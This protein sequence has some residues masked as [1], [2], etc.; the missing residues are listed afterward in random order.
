[1][2]TLENLP[3][4]DVDMDTVFFRV[5]YNMLESMKI[6]KGECEAL[7]AIYET[8]VDRCGKQGYYYNLYNHI[9]KQIAEVLDA[10]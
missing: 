7:L 6:N 10:Y 5:L 9:Y 4:M 8:K 1:M 3:L 2:D